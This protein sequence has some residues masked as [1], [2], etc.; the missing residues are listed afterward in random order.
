[1]QFDQNFGKDHLF[2]RSIRLIK[3]WCYY[4]SHILGA[5]H[6]LIS[7]YAMETLVIYIF[8]TFHKFLD[9]SLVVN[10]GSDIAIEFVSFGVTTSCSKR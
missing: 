8:H 5:Q 7:T 4:E 3:N 1:L 2:K 9:G 6:G 10:Y